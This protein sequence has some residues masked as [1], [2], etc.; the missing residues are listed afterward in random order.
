M[1]SGNHWWENAPPPPPPRLHELSK[2]LVPN[3]VFQGTARVTPRIYERPATVM[4]RRLFLPFPPHPD[5]KAV[6]QTLPPSSSLARTWREAGG[7]P[8]ARRELSLQQQEPA[9]PAASSR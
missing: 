9:V 5:P 6:F 8:V 3:P 2:S 7:C 1:N 4:L